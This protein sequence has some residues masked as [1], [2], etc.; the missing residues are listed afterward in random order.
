MSGQ[1]LFKR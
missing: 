1:I